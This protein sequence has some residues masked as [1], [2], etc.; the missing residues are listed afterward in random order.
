MFQE[1]LGGFHNRHFRE[2]SSASWS[3]RNI[4]LPQVASPDGSSLKKVVCL[5]WELML[6]KEGQHHWGLRRSTETESKWSP[7]SS[8][9]AF[10]DPSRTR[11][12]LLYA[13]VSG[14]DTLLCHT[15]K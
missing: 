13:G 11:K 15:Y 5:S 6:A 14:L 9:K 10:G 8:L 12:G 2:F 3:I 4:T 1:T 7:K